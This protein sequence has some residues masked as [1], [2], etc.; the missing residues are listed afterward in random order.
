MTEKTNIVWTEDMNRYLFKRLYKL[1]G[2]LKS[3]SGKTDSLKKE[4]VACDKIA[5][6]LSIL[7]D[8]EVT[9]D[10][11]T[12]HIYKVAMAPTLNPRF[13][14]VSKMYEAYKSGWL[15]NSDMN[16]SEKYFVKKGMMIDLGNYW[17]IKK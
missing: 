5:T 12:M 8:Q 7:S 16:N 10:K 14:Q 11:V 4:K 3:Y 9:G 2:P 15:T 13:A 6:E 1:L 17:G